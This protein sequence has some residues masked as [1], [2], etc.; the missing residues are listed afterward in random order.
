[1]QISLG[2]EIKHIKGLDELET[3]VSNMSSVF[4]FRHLKGTL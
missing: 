3:Q 1:M 4:L 2:K